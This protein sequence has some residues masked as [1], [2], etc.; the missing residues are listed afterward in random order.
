[1]RMFIPHWDGLWTLTKFINTENTENV[2]KNEIMNSC[3]VGV[4]TKNTVPSCN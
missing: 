3:S 4:P 1:M 2:M